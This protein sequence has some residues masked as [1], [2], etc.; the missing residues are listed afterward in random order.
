[1][2][3]ATATAAAVSGPRNCWHHK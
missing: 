2:V 1:M 3:G